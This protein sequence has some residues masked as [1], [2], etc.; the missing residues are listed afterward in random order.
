MWRMG[1]EELVQ[2]PIFDT[3]TRQDDLKELKTRCITDRYE[4]RWEIPKP[5]REK[6]TLSMSMSQFIF[7]FLDK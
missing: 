4:Y 1:N 6:E 2:Q 3:G 7:K 5:Y